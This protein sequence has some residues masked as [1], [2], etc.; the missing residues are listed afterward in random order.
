M[1]GWRSFI[2]FKK[3][4]HINPQPPVTSAFGIYNRDYFSFKFLM[5][6]FT[7]LLIGKL[8]EQFTH[9]INIF[10]CNPMMSAK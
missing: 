1:S 6:V 8:F 3:L 10:K 5:K 2:I 7:A 9:T 4:D